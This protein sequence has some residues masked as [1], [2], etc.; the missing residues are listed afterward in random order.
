M[1]EVE[2]LSVRYGT[3]E[4]VAKASFSVAEGETLAI[5][6]SNGA[7]KTS[8]LSAIAGVVGPSSG[9]IR[10]CGAD[11]TGS[12]PHRIARRGISLVPEGRQ[13]FSR[14]TVEENLRLGLAA[15]G[16]RGDRRS[17]A[18]AISGVLETFPALQRLRDVRAGTMS[19]GEQQQLAIGR[20]LVTEPRLLCLD[21]PSLGLAPVMVDAVFA[22]IDK[23]QRAGTTLILV[24]QVTAKAVEVSDR[25]MLMR[26]G[27]MGPLDD[28]SQEQL[29]SA[30]LGSDPG[31]TC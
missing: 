28:R 1:L 11:I 31:S 22:T 19:G 4:A 5:V 12:A 7:G 24:E 3:V 6:G 29:E 26:D 25:T 2:A 30:Y 20:A 17:G 14:L 13:I 21:E 23:L 15:R 10:F 18:A 8:L 27:N 16:D 9:R